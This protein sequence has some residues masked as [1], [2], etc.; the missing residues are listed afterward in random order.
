MRQKGMTAVITGA[1]AGIGA[2]QASEPQQGLA[3]LPRKA[4]S[5]V[6]EGLLELLEVGRPDIGDGD[7]LQAARPPGDRVE[8]GHGASRAGG[9]RLD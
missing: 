4:E 1:S 8:S 6:A 7:V 5:G 2:A 3:K 9:E